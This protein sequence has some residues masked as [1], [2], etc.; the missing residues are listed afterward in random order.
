M[1]GR[2]DGRIAII[3]GG[4]TGMGGAASRLFATEGA[5]GA[6]LDRNLAAAEA[7]VAEI[8]AAGGTAAAFE[9]DASDEGAVGEAVAR[10]SERFGPATV[11]FNHAGTLIVKPF[12]ET[13]VAEWD[14]LHAVNV[15]SMFL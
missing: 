14:W 10:A 9:A 2:L 6:I 15:R 8:D 3:S 12:L 5:T 1:A 11:L 13:T 7:T 4:A